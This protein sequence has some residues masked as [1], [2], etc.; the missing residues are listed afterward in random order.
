MSK[1][2]IA[3]NTL[4]KIESTENCYIVNNDSQLTQEVRQVIALTPWEKIAEENAK[5]IKLQRGF[6]ASF[7]ISDDFDMLFINSMAEL[8]R[9]KN[10]TYI[11]VPKTRFRFI[12]RSINLIIKIFGNKQRLFNDTLV[13]LIDSYYRE[14]VRLQNEN[15]QMKAQIDKLA[16]QISKDE[17]RR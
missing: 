3:E 15:A 10:M 6:C 17:E 13:I 11:S 1:N 7:D 2:N 14:I 16:V 8:S 12:R 5:L 9:T 4:A